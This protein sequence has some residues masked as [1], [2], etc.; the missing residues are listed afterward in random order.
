MDEELKVMNALMKGV[1]QML[2]DRTD[3]VE[4]ALSA[5]YNGLDR[6]I[7]E[8]EAEEEKRRIEME[9]LSE[10]LFEIKQN[11]LAELRKAQDSIREAYNYVAEYNSEIDFNGADELIDMTFLDEV[12]RK[13]LEVERYTQWTTEE[14]AALEREGY[15][16]IAEG[17]AA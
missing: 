3:P 17:R 12:S 2:V 14:K 10:K 1:T 5:Y 4:C 8:Y 9:E 13:V 6:D 15:E 11:A 16:M 7:E